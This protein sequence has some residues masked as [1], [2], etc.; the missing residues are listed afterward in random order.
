MMVKTLL[1]GT[2]FLLLMQISPTSL[3]AEPRHE[4]HIHGKAALN[5]VVE[6]AL[7]DAEFRSPLMN[8]VGYEHKATIP[9]ERAQLREAVARLEAVHSLI[10]LPESARCQPQR[11][12]VRTGVGGDLHQIPEQ[13]SETDHDRHSPQNEHDTHDAHDAHDAHKEELNHRDVVAHYRFQCAEP[14]HLDRVTLN[15]FRAFSGIEA[16]HVNLLT[17]QGGHRVELNADDPLPKSGAGIRIITAW[18]N[19]Q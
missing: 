5:L 2:S 12:D 3:A 16:I 11:T 19:Q 17:G 15:F 10:Q 14:Q 6:G 4:A 9:A 8:I 18:Q 13:L 7:V 1:S